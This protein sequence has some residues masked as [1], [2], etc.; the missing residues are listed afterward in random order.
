MADI[1]Q[2]SFMLLVLL[3]SVSAIYEWAEN[4]DINPVLSKQVGVGSLGDLNSTSLRSNVASVEISVE[5]IIQT[6][7]SADILGFLNALVSLFISGFAI[8]MNILFGWIVLVEGIFASIGLGELSI[9]FIGPIA[10]IQ[11]FGLF[12]F[13]RDLVNAVRGITP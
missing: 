1:K 4:E 3:V 13:I 5:N 7:E 8:F 2:A 11:L 10:I 9:I 6:T 12:Y